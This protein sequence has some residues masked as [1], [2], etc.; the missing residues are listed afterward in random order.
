MMLSFNQLSTVLTVHLVLSAD[1]HPF[2]ILDIQEEVG[3]L[4]SC[5]MAKVNFI[6]L[7]KMR[8]KSISEVERVR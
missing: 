4:F 6:Y 7:N 5:E 1:V 2:P 8:Q 3:C